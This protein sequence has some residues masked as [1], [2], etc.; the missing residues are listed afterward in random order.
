M[1]YEDN[2]GI[3]GILEFNPTDNIEIFLKGQVF[4]SDSG[5]DV[6]FN[7]SS[8][9]HV[10]TGQVPDDALLY[11][12][13]PDSNYEKSSSEFGKNDLPA[14]LDTY[15][16]SQKINWNLGSVLLTSVLE[17]MSVDAELA[18][19]YDS[20]PYAF[21]NGNYLTESTDFTKNYD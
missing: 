2:Y 17:N 4:S 19:D 10:L 11:N 13:G 16:V 18:S 15:D 21:Y 1:A 20:A 5:G 8:N 12:P 6:L 9:P 14:E 7:M 3:R